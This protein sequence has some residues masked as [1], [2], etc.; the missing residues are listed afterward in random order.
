MHEPAGLRLWGLRVLL[1]RGDGE[2]VSTLE[3]AGVRFFAR[4]R[5]DIGS[6][7]R[8]ISSPVAWILAKSVSWR[9]RRNGGV[10]A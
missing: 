1:G 2:T 8:L 10:A 5:V 3:L 7:A 9:I 6:W 4:R